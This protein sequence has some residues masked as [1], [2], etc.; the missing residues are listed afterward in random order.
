MNTGFIQAGHPSMGSRVT[1]GLG[2]ENQNLPAFV[3]FADWRGGPIGGAPNWSNG[4]MPAALSGH[5]VSF[6]R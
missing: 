3:V 2:T 5:S 1:Y 4:F 6:L